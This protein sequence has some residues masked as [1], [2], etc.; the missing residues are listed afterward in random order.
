VHA[1]DLAR[2]AATLLIPP[3]TALL[4]YAAILLMARPREP[5]R[6]PGDARSW[7][8]WLPAV[9]GY[10]LR[11]VPEVD[12][13]RVCPECSRAASRAQL[14]RAP[15]SPRPLVVGITLLCP[16][17]L[18]YNGATHGVW[19][20]PERALPTVALIAS[21][22]WQPVLLYK[23]EPELQRRASA[24]GGLPRWHARLLAPALM[25]DLRT[26]TEYDRFHRAGL[27]LGW[28][29]LHVRDQLEASLDSSDP[30]QRFRAASLLRAHAPDAPRPSLVRA[31]LDWMTPTSIEGWIR[32]QEVYEA[33]QFLRRHVEV[34]ESAL[35][36]GLSHENPLRRLYCAFVLGVEGRSAHAT[37]AA[38]I[39]CESLRS[40]QLADDAR[41]A[42]YGLAGFGIDAVPRLEALLGSDDAQQ[43]EAARLLLE[44]LGGMN[45]DLAL[46]RLIS[47]GKGIYL[48]QGL[49]SWW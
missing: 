3:G 27:V 36:E 2:W 42:V 1:I 45:S 34:A 46:S 38:A 21:K 26:G 12:G 14:R 23:L 22:R 48:A 19:R 28:H 29:V 11:G 7:R 17:L 31:T 13:A 8:R 10:D 41:L 9:C 15:V 37:A 20:K 33:L 44:R 43:R 16:G 25:A 24:R 30:R 47:R 18:A 35:V 6:C 39:L 32:L 5:Y 40:N 49:G 4:L